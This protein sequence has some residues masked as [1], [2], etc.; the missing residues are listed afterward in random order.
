VDIFRREWQHQG[1]RRQGG[2]RARG[3]TI[4]EDMGMHGGGGGEL[5]D[6][7]ALSSGVA[8]GRGAPVSAVAGGGALL[9]EEQSQQAPASTGG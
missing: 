9:D 4:G 6:G 7:E 2:V 5:L 3:N 8:G 1:S